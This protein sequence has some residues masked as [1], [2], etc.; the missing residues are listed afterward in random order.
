[1]KRDFVSVFNLLMILLLSVSV[2]AIISQ[3]AYSAQPIVIDHT[4]TDIRQIP[5]SA[6]GQAKTNL[7]IA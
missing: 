3:S 7:H 1:M 2:C 4:C 6:I 5:E